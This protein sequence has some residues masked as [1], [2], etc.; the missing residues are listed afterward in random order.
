MCMSIASLTLTGIVACAQSLL[1]VWGLTSTASVT[2]IIHF[3][4]GMLLLVVPLG[5][6]DSEKATLD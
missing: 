5:F 4:T 3:V 1:L 2:M 6:G